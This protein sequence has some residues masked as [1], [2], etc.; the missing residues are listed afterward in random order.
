[1]GAANQRF[2]V[3]QTEIV[4][5]GASLMKLLIP[6]W[7]PLKSLWACVDVCMLGK[8]DGMMAGISRAPGSC[9]RSDSF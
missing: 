7:E 2:P 9:R 4:L 8:S 6:G 5:G 3:R 1:M